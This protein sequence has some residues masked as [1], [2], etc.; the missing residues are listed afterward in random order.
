MGQGH[1]PA[2][3]QF[4]HH[5]RRQS[6]PDGIESGGIAAG[7]AA[8]DDH[9]INFHGGPSLLKRF[10]KEFLD[11]TLGGGGHDGTQG[12]AAP[13][14]HQGG[15]H[16]DLLGIGKPGFV[17]DIDLGHYQPAGIFLRQFLIGRANPAAIAAPGGPKIHQHRGKNR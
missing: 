2:G 7:S 9:V 6:R 8:D 3:G 11:G 15:D 1:L 14:Q 5:Q 16:F 17:I 10:P 12:P 4:L 13:V